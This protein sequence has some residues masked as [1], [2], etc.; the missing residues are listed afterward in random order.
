M[1]VERD[2]AEEKAQTPT[3]R[4]INLKNCGVIIEWNITL[5]EKETTHM[6]NNMDNSRNYRVE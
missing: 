3:N 2:E 6:S 5:Q 1:A 4:W